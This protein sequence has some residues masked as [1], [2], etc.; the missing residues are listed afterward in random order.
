VGLSE[1]SR[2]T[3]AQVND[4]NLSVF[5]FFFYSFHRERLKNALLLK[6]IETGILLLTEQVAAVIF[7]K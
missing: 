5:F 4:I 2:S 6:A 1:K 3:V 7:V